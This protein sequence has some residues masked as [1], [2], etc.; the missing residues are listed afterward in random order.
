MI[1]VSLTG[2]LTR[3]P[4]LHHI[5]SDNGDGSDVCQVRIAAHDSRGRTVFTDC[6]QWGPGG[7]A[8]AAHL[9]K[10]SLVAFSGELRL[11]ET[12]INGTRRQFFSAV[13]HI[14]FLGSGIVAEPER[15]PS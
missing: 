10:G 2:R 5:D 7:R 14:E 8:A 3:A 4:E 9:D 13:G 12:D 6:A 1:N 15:V 11:R